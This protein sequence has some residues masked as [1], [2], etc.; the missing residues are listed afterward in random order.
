M[1][2]ISPATSKVFIQLFNQL[3]ADQKTI[4]N[5]W[6]SREKSV[7]NAA[8]F[9]G[10]DKISETDRQEFCVLLKKALDAGDFS[11]LMPGGSKA[12][13]V[14][15]EAETK[16]PEPAKDKTILDAGIESG[17]VEVIHVGDKPK[18]EAPPEKEDSA[19]A[20][21]STKSCAKSSSAAAGVLHNA[22]VEFVRT[23]APAPAKAKASAPDTPAITEDRIRELIREIIGETVTT[24]VKAEVKAFFARING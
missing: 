10:S 6:I 21:A 12:P 17:K 19:S 3:N 9:M 14:K 8:I 5:Q 16:A 4:A 13:E 20:E 11:A 7:K 15:A 22:L 23:H 24:S 18:A 1:A 2:K